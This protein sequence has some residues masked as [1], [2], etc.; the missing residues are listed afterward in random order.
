[1]TSSSRPQKAIDPRI[2]AGAIAFGLAALMTVPAV[3]A[4]QPPSDPAVAALIGV[5]TFLDVTQLAR[6]SDVLWIAASGSLTFG[7]WR[8]AA[9][10]P[11][12]P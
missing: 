1:M 8:H 11:V 2:R 12:S 7:L 5:P 4:V 10:G 3:F 6:V 9:S